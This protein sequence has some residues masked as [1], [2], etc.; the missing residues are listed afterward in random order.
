MKRLMFT[1]MTFSALSSWANSDELTYKGLDHR[2]KQSCSVKLSANESLTG[3]N[4][5][6]EGNGWWFNTMITDKEDFKCLFTQKREKDSF[7]FRQLDWEDLGGFIGNY[8][9]YVFSYDSK[10]ALKNVKV[11]TGREASSATL[12]CDSMKEGSSGALIDCDL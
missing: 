10:G 8:V 1:L 11:I 5:S 7:T 6:I 9:D 4:V 2:S 3:T 12:A